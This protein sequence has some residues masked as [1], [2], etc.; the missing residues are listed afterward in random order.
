MRWRWKCSDAR[1]AELVR[2]G[3]VDNVE[4]GA[5]GRDK[6]GGRCRGH[7]CGG[8]MVCEGDVGA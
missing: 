1:D 8:T 6:S 5:G 4:G 2:V 3:D 7:A